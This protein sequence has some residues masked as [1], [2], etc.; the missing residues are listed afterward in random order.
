[1]E[2]EKLKSLRTGN[3]SLITRLYR[4][5]EEAKQSEEFDTEDVISNF[6]KLS[7][8]KQYVDDLNEQIIQLTK[9]ED[10]ENEIIESEEY[11]VSIETKIKHAR[12]FIKEIQVQQPL[13][14]NTSPSH[15]LDIDAPPYSPL[16]T[17][18]HTAHA[19]A[20]PYVSQPLEANH[21]PNTQ[22]SVS[23]FSR[24]STDSHRL[25]KLTLSTFAGNI[26]EGQT[27]WDSFE[28]AVHMNP[29]LTN[30][31][32][33]NYLKAQL[34]SD[35]L[36]SI[37]GFALTNVNYDEAVNVLKERFGQT[38]KIISA[39]LQALLEIP[40]PR[41]QLH[42]LRNF[43][44]KMEAY[45]RGLEA[46]GES[47]ETY[48]KLLVPIIMK[49]L[50]GEIRRNLARE[51]GPSTWALQNLRRSIQNEINI[52]DAGQENDETL[53]PIPTTS[54]FVAGAKPKMRQN[55]ITN[56]NVQ[57]TVENRP[58]VF[59][60]ETHSP[61][62][63]DKVTHPAARMEIVKRD[64]LCF[65]CLG[66]HRLSDCKSNKT[67]KNC[68][69]KHHTS[70]CNKNQVNHANQKQGDNTRVETN[71]PKNQNT[72]TCSH[73]NQNTHSTPTAQVS[74][75]NDHDVKEQ[76]TAILSQSAEFRTNVLLKTAV[77]PVGTSHMYLDTNILF[78]EG[79][80]R[81]FVTKDLAE[82]LNL[83][84]ED[85]EVLQLSAFGGG[86]KTERHLERATVYLR[87]D[88]G[89]R[90]PIKVLVVPIIAMPLQNYICQIDDRYDYIRGLKLAHPITQQDSFEISLL[91]GADYYWDIVED[92][93]IRGNGPT[94]VKS[95]VGYLLSG[96]VKSNRDRKNNDTSTNSIANLLVSLKS[97][98]HSLEKLWNLESI[99][100][101]SKE[102]EQNN[103]EFLKKYQEESIEFHGNKYI[104]GLPWKQD[105]ETLP[106]NFVVAK[107]RTEN[108]IKR[109]SKTPEMLT[110]YGNIIAEQERRD[111]IEKVNDEEISTSKTHYI[112]HHPVYKESSTTPIRIVYDCSCRQ[113]Q[114][115]PSLNDCLMD[116]P[117]QLNDLT[118]I[119][120]RFRAQPVAVTTDIEK[121]FLHIGLK[122][123]D[124]DATRFLWLS[125]PSDPS[126]PL[127]TYRFKSVLF[128]A[129]C[130]PFIL[131][132]TLLK[133]LQLSSSNTTRIMARDLYVDNIIS[134]IDN[135]SNAI[136]YFYESRKTMSEAGFNL[137][138]WTSNSDKI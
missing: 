34:Q 51:H 47:Q 9:P 29:S 43:Y 78:D 118:K 1:M 121:A 77:A 24:T 33:F 71:A 46:L 28:S 100:I 111:F 18:A 104:V 17:S 125:D 57:R 98:D 4:K 27:F 63:C 55:H 127:Q 2:L 114:E 79:A 133:H 59:C 97:E 87:T 74:L 3:K 94:A 88:T 96:P 91:I 11:S 26:L 19:H 32:R 14:D 54:T 116:M 20:Q 58:C 102:V 37:A 136:D 95:K 22:A 45:V 86:D 7:A 73:S 52:M 25:P 50:P 110:K 131:N 5:I 56:R 35:A 92:H 82:K 99:G 115:L 60:H 49:K 42:S 106:T 66:K 137:R 122:E 128:G 15:T 90:V 123:A 124:R 70:L 31:Q 120:M 103:D 13:Q 30:V 119:L 8:K 134:S 64:K 113:S 62:H 44:D 48:G 129:T 109:L 85:T 89:H 83:H 16:S 130:S 23:T 93:V 80:Q 38:D 10:V 138:S 132:A 135:E 68:H 53:N 61:T 65:N 41:N 36:Q 81:S 76:N 117:P 75:V 12:K 21:I 112:P 126:S 101:N 67:C 107:R 84:I 6:E 39:Y 108:V 72:C 40:Q 69:K 105:H